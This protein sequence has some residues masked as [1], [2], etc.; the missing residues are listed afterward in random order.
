G[1]FLMAFAGPVMS[2]IFGLFFLALGELCRM[3]LQNAPLYWVLEYLGMI[4]LLIAAFNLVPAF[5]LDGGRM[6]R[7]AIWHRKKNLV[8]ATRIAS[9]L[10]ATFAYAMLAFACWEIVMH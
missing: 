6:L 9:D 7:A 1:E 3:Y 5:P 10:G 4:N 8:L 2:A